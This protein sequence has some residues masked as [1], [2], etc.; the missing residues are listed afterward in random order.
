VMLEHAI[1]R[2]MSDMR[3]HRSSSSMV[4]VLDAGA[5]TK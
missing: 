5:S 4:G 3:S 2:S 1:A